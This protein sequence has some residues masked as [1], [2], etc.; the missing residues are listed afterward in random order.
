MQPSVVQRTRSEERRCV[1]SSSSS[2]CFL[3][4]PTYTHCFRRLQHQKPAAKKALHTVLTPWA[5]K[6]RFASVQLAR[7]SPLA[8]MR[9]DHTLRSLGAPQNTRVRD[10]A[11]GHCLKI[12]ISYL[13]FTLH[14]LTFPQQPT[15][16]RP[17]ARNN[18]RCARLSVLPG[19]SPGPGVML[20]IY[21]TPHRAS[22]EAA[23]PTSSRSTGPTRDSGRTNPI[24]YLPFANSVFG[25]VCSSS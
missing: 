4:K 8:F 16:K 15:E 18:S 6:T 13:L 3:R 25:F 10:A 11:Y 1:P 7:R 5:T 22:I 14:R 19:R 20:L 2:Y 9:F 21:A 24:F 17:A 23:S 12:L